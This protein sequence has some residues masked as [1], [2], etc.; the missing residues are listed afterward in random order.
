MLRLSY[1]YDQI[2]AEGIMDV[3]FRHIFIRGRDSG[4][5]QIFS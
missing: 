4:R 2:T 3:G 1:R 5:K